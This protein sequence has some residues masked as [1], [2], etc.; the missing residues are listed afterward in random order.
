[1]AG[2]D[3]KMMCRSEDCAGPCMNAKVQYYIQK[4]IRNGH[5]M[6]QFV[7]LPISCLD[8]LP[9]AIFL[10]FECVTG[11]VMI[12]TSDGSGRYEAVKRYLC[13][14]RLCSIVLCR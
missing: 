1:M 13:F 12:V 8:N 11:S 10:D 14:D 9:N 4:K 5:T 6:E 2:A 3:K 7:S